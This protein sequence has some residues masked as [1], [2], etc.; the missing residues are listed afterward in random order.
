[1]AGPALAC[2]G[3]WWVLPARAGLLSQADATAGIRTALERG[4]VSAV[5]LLGRTDGFLGNPKV[6]IPLP[7]FL[8]EAAK[9]LNA[10]GQGKRVDE[11]VVSMNRAAELAVPEAKPILVK[12]AKAITAD[13]AVKI[14]RGNETS[15]TD[16]F[17]GKTRSPLTE[18]FL[19]IV[20]RATERVSLAEK[21]N[22][23]AGR[24][25]QLGFVKGN[26]ANLQRYVTGKS[27]D[28][29]YLMI[30]EEER[31][32]RQDPI[33]TGSAILRKVFGG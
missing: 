8:D 28:G 19:P 18:K 12:A 9:L 6:R 11:L 5:G 16:Y 27:L 29:L 7:K 4:A 32:I 3:C 2:T 1:M 26:D 31:K 21:Y 10:V 33:G 25:S 14:V 15:V 13:D 23:L 20:T 30:G 17:A 24:A 22:A